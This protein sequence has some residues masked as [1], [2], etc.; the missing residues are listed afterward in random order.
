VADAWNLHS[1]F[2]ISD[3]F[4]TANRSFDTPFDADWMRVQIRN[5]CKNGAQ[6]FD[7]CAA[8]HG[9]E[10]ESVLEELVSVTRDTINE[11]GAVCSIGTVSPDV[12]RCFAHERNVILN[13]CSGLLIDPDEML[14][15]MA[16]YQNVRAVI[17]VCADSAGTNVTARHRLEIAK[18][19]AD[20]LATIEI[21]PE[22]IVFDPVTMPMSCG[23]EA[24][25]V[26][27]QTAER[28]RE[29]FPKSGVLSAVSNYSY[30][31]ANHRTAEREYLVKAKSHGATVFLL[32][33]LD[34]KLCEL[35][36]GDSCT[37]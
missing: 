17:A 31:L 19:L 7:F 22:K 24:E 33:A 23:S 16:E 29:T 18:R 10:E 11:T 35:A 13:C 1:P 20:D 21:P 8:T 27:H 14:R 25:K 5:Q 15:A 6:A 26:T 36:K 4:N 9:A 2:L 12:L 32:N 34:A 37:G 30:G 28:L 3:R